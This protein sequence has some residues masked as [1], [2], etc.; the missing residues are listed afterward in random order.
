MAFSDPIVGTE[1][2]IRNQMQSEGFSVDP[3]TG[4]TGWQIKKD[5]TAT[6]NNL[7]IG[8]SNYN[9]DN[10]GN[11]TFEGITANSSFIYQGTELSD[12]LAPF[13]KGLVVATTLTNTGTWNGSTDLLVGRLIIPDYDDTRSYLIGYHCRMDV[14]NASGSFMDLK[15]RYAWDANTTT[16]S[17]EL[18]DFQVGARDATSTNDSGLAAQRPLTLT[19]AGTDL[20]LGA[21]ITFSSTFNDAT[22]PQLDNGHTAVMWVEDLGPATDF[23][24]WDG[25][26]GSGGGNPVQSYTKT[27]NC[28]DSASFDSSGGNRAGF[29]SG[30]CFQGYYSGTNGNQF[31]LITF[32][33]STIASDLSGATITKVEV[34][35]DNIHWYNNSGGTAIIGTHTYTTVTGDA[36]YANVDPNISSA[37]FTYGQAKWVTVSNSIGTAFKNGTAKGIALGKGPSTSHTYYGYFSGFGQ[38]GAPKLRITYSK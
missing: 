11:A 33:Y 5:G 24:S 20:H 21:Y 25:G 32:P 16:S 26:G 10:N 38:S 1:V 2:L 15:I 9:I 23:T 12:L 3:E 18:I 14:N 30:H 8:G 17:T 28:L 19:A 29:D 34:Y 27:Y 6:F 7:V 31:S 13:P 35:L 37:S 4:V 22:R 36:N